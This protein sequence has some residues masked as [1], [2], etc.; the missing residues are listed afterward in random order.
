MDSKTPLKVLIIGSM[1]NLVG[2][3]ALCSFMGYGIA[4]AAWATIASQVSD[5]QSFASGFERLHV[6]YC[7]CI[8]PIVLCF[9]LAI[10]PCLRRM[11]LR[12]NPHLFASW[13]WRLRLFNA[14][15]FA[16][17]YVAGILMALSLNN[18][19]YNALNI[20]VPSVKELVDIVKLT[21]P[22]LLSMIS[23]VSNKSWYPTPQIYSLR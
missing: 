10:S 13:W 8:R 6:S 4:G 9:F 14:I 12:G 16:F 1:F 17:Q 18:K 19:G 22:L 11:S 5:A 2:D 23:K 15:G 21:A 3:V 20:Q 7:L